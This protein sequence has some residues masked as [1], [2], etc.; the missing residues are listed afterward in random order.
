MMGRYG[1]GTDQWPALDRLVHKES[2]W[3]PAAANPTSTA[4]GLFQFLKSTWAGYISNRGGPPYW[5]QD[6]GIQ[7]KGGLSYI[8]ERYGSPQRALDFH[9]GHNWYHKGGMVFPSMD[10]G[11]QV[12]GDG[13]AKVHAGETVL[14][15]ALTKKVES[16][17][18]SNGGNGDIYNFTFDLS[19][20]MGSNRELEKL[21]D[22][23]ETR[24]LPKFRRT[25]GQQ[26]RRFTKV[27]KS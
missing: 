9:L 19:G 8:K 23:M 7:A 4:R 26:N 15:A 2:S 3:N 1:W 10:V 17:L 6:V 22:T 18:A 13:F 27:T 24:V 11:G 14:T 16:M 12:Y 5:S 25:E 21:V 20:Y